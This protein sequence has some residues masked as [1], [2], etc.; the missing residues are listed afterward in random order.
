[1]MVKVCDHNKKKVTGICGKRIVFMHMIR[2][3][4]TESKILTMKP[5]D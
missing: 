2:N 4:K 5:L 3:A 1:M